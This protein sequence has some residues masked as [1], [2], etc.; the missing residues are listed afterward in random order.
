[1]RRAEMISLAE[2]SARMSEREG[3]SWR[4]KVT[5]WRTNC[6][7]YLEERLHLVVTDQFREPLSAIQPGVKVAIES[8]KGV[9]KTEYA[10]GV[11]LWWVECFELNECLTTASSWDAL[12]K[13]LWPRIHKFIR[14]FN[15]F[16]PRLVND[17]AINLGANGGRA[18]AMSVKHDVNLQGA[19]A[20]YL[21]QVVEESSGI[22]EPIADA[23]DGN[24]TGEKG[25]Q[26]WFGNPKRASGPFFDRC[27]KDPTFKVF[28][29]SAFDHPNIKEGREVIP[30]AV[31]RKKIE[32]RAEK[33]CQR[34]EPGAAGAIH[35]FWKAQNEGWYIPSNKFRCDVMGMP[36]T[37][38]ENTLISL[39]RIERAQKRN[40]PDTNGAIGTGCDVARFG[41]DDTVIVDVT[42]NGILNIDRTHGR[43]TTDT[44]GR[45]IAAHRDKHRAIAVDDGGLGAGVSDTLHDKGVDHLEINFAN[46][47]S[48]KE[49]FFNMK[50]ELYWGLKEE[51]EHNEDFY[52]PDDEALT[53]EATTIRYTYDGQG[54][55]K[56]ESKEEYRARTGKSPDSL[57]ALLLA[58][59]AL[60]NAPAYEIATSEERRMSF[61]EM[62]V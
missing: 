19:H 17:L 40:K 53:N 39:D 56:I 29:I 33:L 61:D 5:R 58:L 16:D 13:H 57:E 4:E 51:L 54:R 43:R 3:E 46:A 38:D 15:L 50:A 32:E 31:S 35:L 25:A 52:W 12:K 2:D 9:G 42:Y 20:A 48:D 8:A 44:A 6:V 1:M 45:L 11:V 28:R 24:D 7:L 60:K 55:V 18:Y 47:T 26:A 23:I 30:G 21:L 22:E 36:P 49:S 10:A 41:S 59:Y 27:H 34:A 14:K 37:Q 62:P